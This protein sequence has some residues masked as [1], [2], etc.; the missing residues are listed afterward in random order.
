MR[1]CRYGRKNAKAL[2]TSARGKACS[3][4]MLQSRF[5]IACMLRGDASS[6]AAL[7]LA[8]VRLSIRD[9]GLAW[10]LQL[11]LPPLDGIQK[12]LADEW[13]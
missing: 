13:K 6:Q 10:S 7:D 4:A 5:Q 9:A 12:R 1:R 2:H 8:P 11:A 3:A